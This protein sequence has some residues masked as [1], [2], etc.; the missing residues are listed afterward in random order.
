[1]ILASFCRFIKNKDPMFEESKIAPQQQKSEKKSASGLAQSSFSFPSL[2]T[3]PTK[4]LQKAILSYK[5]VDKVGSGGT[6]PANQ[7]S[8][9]NRG[10]PFRTNMMMWMDQL[11]LVSSMAERLRAL[12]N[13]TYRVEIDG[14]EATDYSDS[15]FIGVSVNITISKNILQ[16]QVIEEEL[17]R[18]MAAAEAIPEESKRVV[19]VSQPPKLTVL[20]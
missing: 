4:T 10:I 18:E 20:I 1:M 11:G 7:A 12:K 6:R 14:V 17:K 15:H 19:V 16:S 13:E 9:L 2:N 5:E 8:F 3:V